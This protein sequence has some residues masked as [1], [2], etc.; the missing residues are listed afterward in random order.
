MAVRAF[1]VINQLGES[2]RVELAKPRD[3]GFRVDDIRGL[4]PPKATINTSKISTLDGAVFNSAQIEG[5][6]I[7]L[8][9]GLLSVNTIEEAR[10]KSYRYFPIKGEVS[11]IVETDKRTALA[12]GWVESN[13]PTMF[14]KEIQTTISI[15]CPDAFLLDASD[16]NIVSADFYGQEAGFEFPFSNESLTVPLIELGRI[17]AIPSKIINYPGDGE[18]GMVISIHVLGSATN[19]V[20]YNVRTNESMRIDTDRLSAMLGTGLVAGDHIVINTQKGKKGI[21]LYRG[22]AQYNILNALDRNVNWLVL[23]KG[24]NEFTYDTL[25]G[26]NNIQMKIEAAILYEGV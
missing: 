23:R 13:E 9:L 14:A 8:T 4:T 20:I 22:S 1:T 12:T 3:T 2:L 26:D 10:L 15:V 24:A 7:V 6:N 11:I 25:T 19:V 21:T 5:R 18:I 17:V 16:D